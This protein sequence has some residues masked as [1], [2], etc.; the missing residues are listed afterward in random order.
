MSQVAP[1]AGGGGQGAIAVFKNRPFLLLWLA[2]A[3]TQIGGNMVL[4]GLTVIVSSRGPN[5]LVSILILTFLIPAVLFSA[6]A[7]VYVD[8]MDRRLVLVVTN[9]VRAFAFIV[10]F[11]VQDNLALLLVLNFFVSSVNVFFS[12]AEASMIPILVRRSQLITANGIF[13]LTL[14]GA[15]AIG[16]ALLGPFT[17]A[18]AGPQVLILFVAVLF[19]VATVFCITLPSAPPVVA[20]GIHAGEAVADAERA[21]QT[22][23]T[24]LREGIAYIRSNPGISWSLVYLGIAAS[25]LGV[26]GVLGPDFAR[27]TL[28]LRTEDLV[29]VV[30][31]LGGGL[32]TGI[33]LLNAYGRF[34]P[35]RRVIESGLIALGILLALLSVAGPISRLLQRAEATSDL[36]DLSTITSLLSVV[37]VIAFMA[38]ISYALVAI[39]SQTQLHE[40]IPADARGR[41]FGVLNMLVSV[42]S[43]LPII[44][45]GPISD[46]FGTTVVILGVATVIGL[47]GVASVVRRGPLRPSESRST[48]EA[49]LIGVIDRHPRDGEDDA[50]D[51]S[52]G[53]GALGAS[54][55]SDATEE[56]DPTD[57]GA[58]PAAF[59]P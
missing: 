6:L 21:V 28:G 17:V 31:P 39:P 53:R 16:F 48:A 23:V 27:T 56:F 20:S 50:S 35:R 54:D 11:I 47:S 51:D 34:L 5:S 7:G 30:L 57:D 9:I 58:P 52:D 40:D 46:V 38:G 44:I 26:L 55:E 8:R 13:T 4:Y 32:V 36:L 15:F 1:S 2:Q 14:N 24:Q 59:R 18:L 12:P 43:F 49:A 25:L 22:T 41:V 3:A 37:V 45:V 29:V 42:S 19:F 33:L 10:I